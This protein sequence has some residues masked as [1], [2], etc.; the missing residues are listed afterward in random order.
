MK[1]FN[2]RAF[3][4]YIDNRT[5]EK[6]N[7]S[8]LLV[9]N[10]SLHS[11]CDKANALSGQYSSVFTRDNLLQPHFDQKMPVNSLTGV[12]VEETNIVEAIQQM[13]KGSAPGMDEISPLFISKVFPNLVKPLGIIFKKSLETGNLPLDW[14]S[15]LIVPIYKSNGKPHDCSSYR[16]V[17]LTSIVCRILESVIRKQ[18]VN[19]LVQNGLISDHQHGFMSGRSTCTNLLSCLRDWTSLANDNVCFDVIYLDFAKA[20]DTVSHQ[21]L[22]QKIK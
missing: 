12:E 7:V 16:P 17:C 5:T 10:S 1:N 4:S 9:N 2:P 21:K 3:F 22:L 11:D 15:G 6:H 13:N 19:F 18:L 8:S 14:K 20:F